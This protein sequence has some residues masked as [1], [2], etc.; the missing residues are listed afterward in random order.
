[1]YKSSVHSSNS[2]FPSGYHGIREVDECFISCGGGSRVKKSKAG[3]VNYEF[4][5]ILTKEIE[6][7]VVEKVAFE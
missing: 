4:H 3:K 6:E 2:V 1:M 5:L 7:V